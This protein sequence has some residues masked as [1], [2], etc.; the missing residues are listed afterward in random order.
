MQLVTAA[1]PHTGTVRYSNRQPLYNPKSSTSP[2]RLF[3][4]RLPQLS[5][6]TTPAP[7]RFEWETLWILLCTYTHIHTQSQGLI[8]YIYQ[9]PIHTYIHTYIHTKPRINTVHTSFQ[10][11]H[12][13]I[14]TYLRIE[15]CFSFPFRNEWL[16]T[17]A[18]IGTFSSF[19]PF[20]LPRCQTDPENPNI[21]MYVCMPIYVCTVCMKIHT[22]T[23]STYIFIE[24]EVYDYR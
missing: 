5:A 1:R 21:C 19:L 14:H 15:N 12:T 4:G 22:T 10:Y 11:I 9:F 3:G 16:E 17:A 24:S 6:S 8:Q 2:T 18:D 13:Y 7:L 20:V 23:Y